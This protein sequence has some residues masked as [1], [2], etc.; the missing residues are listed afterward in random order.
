MYICF[1]MRR[2][3][4]TFFVFLLF[5]SLLSGISQARELTLGFADFPSEIAQLFRAKFPDLQREF[6]SLGGGSAQLFIYHESATGEYKATLIMPLDR[7][8]FGVDERRVTRTKLDL[9]PFAEDFLALDSYR[10]EVRKSSPDPDVR[11]FISRMTMSIMLISFEGDRED[12][13]EFYG[14]T[15]FF[16]GVREAIISPNFVFVRGGKKPITVYMQ[17]T[18]VVSQVFTLPPARDDQKR[19]TEASLIYDFFRFQY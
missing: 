1:A 5:F 15:D 18:A 17:P 4:A 7:S 12:I 6:K 16:M 11:A 3:L 10:I 14:E 19:L 2:F 9:R 8:V 13:F